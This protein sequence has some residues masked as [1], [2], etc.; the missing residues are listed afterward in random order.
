MLT[1]TM[2]LLHSDLHILLK[3]SSTGTRI[4]FIKQLLIPSGPNAVLILV[5]LTA[6]SS[7]K[8][9]ISRDIQASG[10]FPSYYHT[11]S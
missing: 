4:F 5:S 10:H 11:F 9:E 1:T 8:I 7:S 6:L 3:V 2:W